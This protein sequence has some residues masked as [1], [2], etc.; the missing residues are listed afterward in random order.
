MFVIILT[1]FISSAVAYVLYKNIRKYHYVLYGLSLLTALFANRFGDLISGGYISFG[2]FLVVQ[3]TTVFPKKSKIRV[4]LASVR[5]EYAV[6]ASILIS[7]HAVNHILIYIKY[8]FPNF[9]SIEQ[10][11]GTIAYLVIIPLFIT[12]FRTVRKKMNYKT[13]K[14]LHRIAYLFY[15]SMMMHVILQQNENIIFYVVLFIIYIILK[16]RVVIRK[17]AK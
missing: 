16:I 2:L 13:W 14:R 15:F 17:Q 11:F 5:A 4:A 6:I 9:S 1:A 7:P 12:S 10:L 8:V 3:F